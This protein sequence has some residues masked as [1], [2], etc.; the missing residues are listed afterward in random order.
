MFVLLGNKAEDFYYKYSYRFDKEKAIPVF[1][2]SEADYEKALNK[3]FPPEATPPKTE[4][5]M[6]KI[7]VKKN[8]RSS[9][10]E[11]VA[12]ST[13]FKTTPEKVGHREERTPERPEKG[14]VSTSFRTT[15]ETA[16]KTKSS[17][18][19]S[20]FEETTPPPSV[21]RTPERPE[22]GGR[23]EERTPETRS[24]YTI[25]KLGEDYIE[26]MLRETFPKFSVENMAMIHHSGDIHM[27]DLKNDILYMFEI[28]NKRAINAADM[29]KFNDDIDGLKKTNKNV[30]GVMLSLRCHIPIYGHFSIDKNKVYLT[31]NFI[32]SECLRIVVDSYTTLLKGNA[33]TKVEKTEFVIPENIYVLLA[34]ISSEY[35]DLEEQEAMLLEQLKMNEKSSAMATTMLHKTSLKKEFI[36]FIRNEFSN[37]GCINEIDKRKIEEE[38]EVSKMKKWINETAKSKIT[39]KGLIEEFPKLK[40]MISSATLTELLQRFKN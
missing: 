38:M 4:V 5:P 20:T 30:I 31:E 3:I 13:S 25:G 8:N 39:K 14:A 18:A 9:R 28:K 6:M 22:K 1:I 24:G 21:I 26:N 7:K 19:Y 16:E 17:S 29:D 32:N 35:K 37:I 23:L 2:Q 12:V 34:R 36:N 11:K 27:R 33:E 15:P 10:P 40:R